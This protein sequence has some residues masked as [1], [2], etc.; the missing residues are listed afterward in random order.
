MAPGPKEKFKETPLEIATIDGELLIDVDGPS[1]TT[2]TVKKV[3]TGQSESSDADCGG[4]YNW[5]EAVGRS[6]GLG[7]CTTQLSDGF[8]GLDE[9]IRIYTSNS[10]NWIYYRAHSGSAPDMEATYSEDFGLVDDCPD[11]CDEELNSS[12]LIS[13]MVTAEGTYKSVFMD[14]TTQPLPCSK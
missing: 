6:F 8:V 10:D 14:F 9:T 4:T 12:Y 13:N 11:T 5:R 3:R 2:I 7:G 1:S